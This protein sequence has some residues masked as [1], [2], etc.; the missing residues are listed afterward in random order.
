[1]NTTKSSKFVFVGIKGTVIA[2]DPAT[3]KQVW[4]TRLKG[5]EFVN[6]VP[7]DDRLYATT[8]GEIFCLD[9]ATGAAF[10]HNPLKGFGVGLAA[11]VVGS[12]VPPLPTAVLAEKQRLDQAAAAAHS[13]AC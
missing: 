5:S 11:I 4:G 6:V 7:D 9:A 1:M 8:A 3:G 2:L 13:A 10:W 12:E